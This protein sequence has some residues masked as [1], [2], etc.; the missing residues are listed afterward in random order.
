MRSDAHWLEQV[1]II[2]GARLLPADWRIGQITVQGPRLEMAV[3]A[4]LENVNRCGAV[5]QLAYRRGVE[6]TCLA[7]RSLPAIRAFL[8]MPARRPITEP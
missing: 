6:R 2:A 8:V 5:D 3:E 1:R 7:P 4:V